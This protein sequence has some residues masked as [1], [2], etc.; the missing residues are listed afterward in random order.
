MAGAASD[1]QAGCTHLPATS[2]KSTGAP[3]S[4]LFGIASHGYDAKS[5]A[6]EILLVSQLRLLGMRLRW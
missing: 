3:P 5:I 4:L 6:R 1:R 2:S